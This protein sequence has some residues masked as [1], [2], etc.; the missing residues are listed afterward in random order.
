MVIPMWSF[1]PGGPTGSKP[2]HSSEEDAAFDD[3]VRA[4]PKG[5]ARANGHLRVLPVRVRSAQASVD[6]RAPSHV[7]HE[8][9]GML[10]PTPPRVLGRAEGLGQFGP[11]ARVTGLGIALGAA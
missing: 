1:I 8:G 3:L 6:A 2:K 7:G 11:V 9:M 4:V 5:V 10:L